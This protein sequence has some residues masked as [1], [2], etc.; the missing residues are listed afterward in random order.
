MY[1]ISQYYLAALKTHSGKALI[2]HYKMELHRGWQ[3]IPP[4]TKCTQ[5]TH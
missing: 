1:L 3:K 2:V 4:T 5:D